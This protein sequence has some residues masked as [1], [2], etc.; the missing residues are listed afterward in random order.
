[1]MKSFPGNYS[2]KFKDKT[3]YEEVELITFAVT[4]QKQIF[5]KRTTGTLISCYDT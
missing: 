3:P 2:C 4:P 1:M 5:Y